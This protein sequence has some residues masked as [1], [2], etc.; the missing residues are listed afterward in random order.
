MTK[1]DEELICEVAGRNVTLINKI[2]QSF[3][4]LEKVLGELQLEEPLFMT[5]AAKKSFARAA[6][7]QAPL[8]RLQP[9]KKSKSKT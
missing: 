9:V 4:T 2:Y 3:E 5:Y 6:M 7:K 1:K 8:C